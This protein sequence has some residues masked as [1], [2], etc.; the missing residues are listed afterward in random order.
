[1]QKYVRRAVKKVVDDGLR[2]VELI[3]RSAAAS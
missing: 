1:M 3:V 2:K